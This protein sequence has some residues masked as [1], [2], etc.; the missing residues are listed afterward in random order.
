MSVR[1]RAWKTAKG[2]AKEAWV[3]DYVDQAGQRHIKTFPKKKEADAYHATARVEVRA[4]EHTPNSASVTVKAAAENW[5][6]SCEARNLERRTVESYRQHVKFH[7]LPFIGAIKLSQLSA[8]LVRKFE[9][10]LR[11][12]KPAPANLRVSRDRRRWCAR[13]S[14]VSELSSPMHTSAGM[15][16]A[17]S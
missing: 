15:S 8:P 4:G 6:T 7:I 3:V 12:G 5:I 16:H 14:G 1:K 11:N 2:E 17:T 10:D 9:D 13:L